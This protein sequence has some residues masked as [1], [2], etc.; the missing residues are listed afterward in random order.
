[1]RIIY[2]QNDHECQGSSRK[3]SKLAVGEEW[4]VATTNP[5]VVEAVSIE[6]VTTRTVVLR[7]LSDCDY[8]AKPT[9]AVRRY[10]R[11]RVDFIERISK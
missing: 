9:D 8:T 7:R 10:V 5:Q 3:R 1:M 11:D 6:E 4:Y 2:E